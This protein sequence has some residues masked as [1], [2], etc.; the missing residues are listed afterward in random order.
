MCEITT[1]A[2]PQP[3]DYF[4][5]RVVDE[6]T[7][8]G[9]P[10]VEL[11]TVN[12]IR[13]YTDS[14]GIIAFHEPGLMDRTVFFYVKSHGYEY[15]AD[16][17]GYRGKALKVSPGGRAEL[18]LKRVNI[19]ERLYRVT[20]AGIYRDSVLVGEPV[21]VRNPL[22]NARVLGSDSVE[23]VRFQGKLHWFWGDTNRPGYVL[24][25]F[26]VP[27]ATS[28]LPA[29][30]GLDPDR[31]VEL[32]YYVDDKGFARPCAQMP[33]EGPTW[34]SG[35]VVLWDKY[36]REHMYASY[37]K[38][39]G[40]LEIHRRGLA[41][42]NTE[43]RRFEQVTEFGMKRPV[44]PRGHTFRRE[45]DRTEYIYFAD[46]YPL[47]RVRA[48]AEALRNLGMYETFTCLESGTRLDPPVPDRD[49]EGR[50]RYGW[51]RNAPVVGPGDQRR[52]IEAGHIKP[53][54]ALLQL[55]DVDTGSTVIAHRGSVY[56]NLWRRRWVMITVETGGTSQLGE[57]WFA[58]ADTPVGPW[59]YARKI[60][61]HDRY[62]F[63]NPKQHPAFNREDGRIIYFEGTYAN[64]F[65]GNNN[66]TPRYDYNQIMYKLDLSD[67]RLNLPVAFRQGSNDALPQ[68]LRPEP[69][70]PDARPN[71]IA[72]FACERAGPKTIP[73]Y[74]GTTPGG[75]NMLTRERPKTSPG[76]KPHAPLFHAL[77]AD[78]ENPPATTI[79]L[80]EFVRADTAR[81]TYLT[82]ADRTVPGHRRA[83]KPLCRVWRS[84]FQDAVKWE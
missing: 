24:G 11:R 63:Y 78:L 22:L 73:I 68:P 66:Q 81:C 60:V 4:R 83:E 47:V 27:G 13:Y 6:Q 37:V 52:L 82:D 69:N 29:D 59:V 26:H 16:G 64:T 17:F 49:A 34:I 38:V 54:E 36:G 25:N 40:F 55:Q 77:P 8:R 80:W 30:G 23:C 42:F 33:S 76:E 19:A 50:L 67:A 28:L 32:T 51:R 70:R 31:G 43:T 14:N 21:P 65:S 41:K 18:D 2:A 61:T 74:A 5:I 44:Y 48:M 79:G 20:G 15:P 84:P 12:N 62:S 56:W 9:V 3:N 10:L 75:G 72:F 57:V 46:P 35:L 53:D 39:R 7:G 45:L 1:A 71:R 58:E